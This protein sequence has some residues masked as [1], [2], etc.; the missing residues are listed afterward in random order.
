MAL[1][2]LSYSPPKGARFTIRDG[3]VTLGTG[4]VTEAYK[5]MDPKEREVFLKGKTRK[6]KEAQAERL[7]ELEEEI[8]KKRM[9]EELKKS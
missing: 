3:E 4:V 5:P 8:R 6:Q 1:L 7:K 2:T 9:E